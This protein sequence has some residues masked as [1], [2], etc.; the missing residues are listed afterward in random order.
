MRLV[1]GLLNVWR[2]RLG[3]ALEGGRLGLSRGRQ[4]RKVSF[5]DQ[6]FAKPP[7]HF[8]SVA[9]AADG[10]IRPFAIAIPVSF[11]AAV[12][13]LGPRRRRKTRG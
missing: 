1:H 3:L 7:G 8:R 13:I 5:V 4:G 10:E 6:A 9:L 11:P 2:R 12:A